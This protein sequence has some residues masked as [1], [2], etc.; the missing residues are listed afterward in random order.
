MRHPHRFLLLL[1][2]LSAGCQQRYPEDPLF[3]YS[4][5]VNTDGSPIPGATI[6]L[7]RAPPAPLD[8][9]GPGAPPTFSP[10]GTSTTQANGEFTFQVLWGDVEENRPDTYIQYRFRLALPLDA[11]GQGTFLSFI[12][13]GDVEL[14]A[15]QPWDARLAVSDSPQGPTLTF[16]PAPPT[17][18]LPPSGKLRFV[19]FHEQGSSAPQEVQVPTTT[20]EAI[21]HFFSGG[22]PMWRQSGVTS[23]WVPGPHLMED[24]ASPE[25]QLRAL[26]L[27]EWIFSPVGGSWSATSFRQEWRTGRLALPAGASRPIS[28][29]AACQP[30]LSGECPWT[31]GQ[32]TPVTISGTVEHGPPESLVI[33]LAEP[34]HLRRA[35]IR[36][37]HFE[38]TLNGPERVRLEGSVDGQ[39]WTPLAEAVVRTFEPQRMDLDLQSNAFANESSWDSPFQDERLAPPREALVFLDLPLQTQEPVRYVRLRAEPDYQPGRNLYLYSLAELS[40]FP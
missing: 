5:A 32:L 40:V 8:P 1:P 16:A 24:F 13:N 26:S 6:A 31:D 33:T 25:V 30:S 3:G 12:L 21:A 35:V 37:L 27:G 7:E 14:P 2:L 29:G 36:G 22:L 23:P 39:Q 15:L 38:S 20:P 19:Y 17:P 18:P 11:N 34:T 10:Y 28:R 9:A 4:R